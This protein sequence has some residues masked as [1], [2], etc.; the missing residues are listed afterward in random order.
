MGSHAAVSSTEHFCLLQKSIWGARF[1]SRIN[2]T[3][4]YASHTRP[5]RFSLSSHNI[6]IRLAGRPLS[7]SFSS[8]HTANAIICIQRFFGDVNEE[9]VR[10]YGNR[11]DLLQWTN[12][13]K[14]TACGEEVVDSLV[15]VFLTDYGTFIVV[16][17]SLLFIGHPVEMHNKRLL[18]A[19]WLLYSSLNEMFS[20][21]NS[22]LISH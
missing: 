2:G 13:S 20:L 21:P 4:L 18:N 10:R 9:G 11:P 17:L 6:R 5:T 12:L 3:I 22:T 16:N 8:S 15:A 14:T 1:R 7:P 19:R